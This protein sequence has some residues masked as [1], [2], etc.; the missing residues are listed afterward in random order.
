MFD[1]KDPSLEINPDDMGY[2]PSRRG[3]RRPAGGTK[4][5]H[6]SERCEACKENKGCGLKKKVKKQRKR[7]NRVVAVEHNNSSSS[8]N[9]NEDN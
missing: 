2:F 4:K 6:D 8:N 7:C 9:N 5:S 3:G 1:V